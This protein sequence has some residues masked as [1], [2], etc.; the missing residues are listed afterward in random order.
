MRTGAEYGHIFDH[1]TTDY[2]NPN[3][4]T[5]IGRFPRTP[6]SK[7]PSRK[8]L[9]E[10]LAPSKTAQTPNPKIFPGKTGWPSPAGPTNPKVQSPPNLIPTIPP[11]PPINGL[12]TGAGAPLPPIMPP[13]SPS[14]ANLFPWNKPLAPKSSL[15]PPSPS[16]PWGPS[17]VPPVPSPGKTQL[18]WTG[19]SSRRWRPPPPSFPPPPSPPSVPAPPV[20]SRSPSR[21]WARRS[22]SSSIPPTPFRRAPRRRPLPPPPPPSTES[23]AIPA[24][25]A[26]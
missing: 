19:G 18:L 21:T 25:K 1:F 6:A 13:M 10:T 14:P 17:P 4:V 24:G 11:G 15:F 16:L 23:S 2:E 5:L 22:A 26:G 8:A 12:K 3:G 9:V 20:P 7:A